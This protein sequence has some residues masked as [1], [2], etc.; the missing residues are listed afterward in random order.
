MLSEELKDLV[1]KI[2][3]K[4]CEM[5]NI[6]LK[7]AEKGTPTRLYDTLSSFSNQTGGG[8]IIFGINEKNDYEITGVFDP[9]KLQTDVTNQ[10][11]QMEPV[12]R[13][14]F[15]KEPAV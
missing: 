10:S 13:P 2:L 7:S 14:V 11:L 9:Q 5:Q 1:L 4:K 15:I 3:D 8:I 6:E 12:V